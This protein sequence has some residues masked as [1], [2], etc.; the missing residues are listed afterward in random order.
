MKKKLSLFKAK[1]LYFE[2]IAYLK[3]H[4]KLFDEETRA[5]FLAKLEEAKRLIKTNKLEEASLTFCELD[6]IAEKLPKMGFFKQT[7]SWGVYIFLTLAV[8]I[9]LRSMVVELMKIPTGSM[10]PTLYEQDAIV[11]GKTA[12]GLNVPFYPDQFYLDENLIKRS[13]IAVWTGKGMP[14]P[15]P[16]QTY[17]LLFKGKKQYVKRI[18]G[19]GGDTVY[20]Y[21]G[22]LYGIDKEGHDISHELEPDFAAHI[23]HVPFHTFG[24]DI[25]ETRTGSMGGSASLFHMNELI[26]T[27]TWRGK[28]RIRGYLAKPF[29]DMGAFYNVWGFRNYGI[30]RIVS[31]K[32]YLLLKDRPQELLASSPYYLEIFHH[33]T[34]KHPQIK[35][36][37]VT[38]SLAPTVGSYRT[39]LPLSSEHLQ[40]IHRVLYTARFVVKHGKVAR[41]GAE[42]MFTRHAHLLPNVTGV[43]NGT[44][45]YYYGKAYRIYPFGIRRQLPNTHRLM[46]LTDSEVQLFYNLGIECNR[47]LSPERGCDDFLPARYVYFREGDLVTMNG[48][49]MLKDDPVLQAFNASEKEKA[50]HPN[51]VHAYIPFKDYGPPLNS[52]GTI[53]KAFIEKYGYK[54]PEQR[55]L[56]LGDNYA[57]S[58]D[59]RSF[60]PVPYT[61]LRGSPLFAFFPPHSAFTPLAQPKLSPLGYIPLIVIGVLILIGFLEMI[62]FI[63]K[64]TSWAKR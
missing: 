61:Q 39:Y 34:L 28:H 55:L 57:M 29:S 33:P 22:K 60:G 44:Y 7:L 3:K 36:S 27:L 38:G 9:A 21:G 14:L 37:P 40:A 23:D 47:L 51:S 54:I 15:D 62:F 5:A 16:D 26:A 53:D 19:K 20:F 2:R 12:F 50:S 52:D 30:S 13:E 25:K 59:S 41:Y 31:Q 18:M 6:Q 45:E 46:Q 64:Y 58:N 8:V 48:A 42:H 10:R 24:G 56:M 63:R 32:E 35:P 43:A 1:K 17:F 4:K 49:F 11:V